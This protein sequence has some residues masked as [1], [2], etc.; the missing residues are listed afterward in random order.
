MDFMVSC[1][2]QKHINYSKTQQLMKKVKTAWKL[3]VKAQ[4]IFPMQVGTNCYWNKQ[5]KQCH[6]SANMHNTSSKT[7]S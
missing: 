3:V 2:H 5:P 7:S 6:H 1:S 4:Y